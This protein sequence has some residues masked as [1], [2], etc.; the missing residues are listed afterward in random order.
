MMRIKKENLAGLCNFTS[1][2][3]HLYNEDETDC[4][5][6]PP[7]ID[8]SYDRIT[9]SFRPIEAVSYGETIDTA[10]YDIYHGNPR[11]L[12]DPVDKV[13]YIVSLPVALAYMHR[14]DVVIMHDLVRNEDG[15]V[16]GCKSFAR[17]RGL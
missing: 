7:H 14:T 1:R 4:I 11:G 3:I 13:L 16:I 10:V 9:T 8:P 12:P 15:K 5:V 17:Y 2:K 6:I